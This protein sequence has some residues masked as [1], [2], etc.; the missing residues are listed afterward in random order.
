LLIR[1]MFLS[2]GA[3]MAALAAHSAP[4]LEGPPARPLTDPRSIESPANSDASPAS[5]ADLYFARGLTDAA[6]SPDGQWIVISTNLTGRYNLWRLPAAGGFPEQLTVSDDRNGDIA[7]TRGGQVLF[8][9][10][11]AGKEIYDLWAVP[12]SGG[13]SVNLTATPEVSE[14]GAIAAPD[15]R[16]IVFNRRPKSS[17]STDVAIIDLP[18]RQVRALTHEAAPDHTWN[19]VGFA[20]GG[21]TIIADRGDF[22]DVEQSVWRIDAGSGAAVAVSPQAGA[23]VRGE[24]VSPDGRWVAVTFETKAGVRQ[25][26]LISVAGGQVTPL[27]P[28]VW[29]QSAEDFSPDGKVLI[30]AS[31][32]DG[33]RTLYAYDLASRVSKPLP[34]PAGYSALASSSHESFSPDGASLLAVRQSSNASVELWIVDLRTW[35]AAP[36]THLGLASL[37][38]EHLPASQVVHYKSADGTVV[39]AFLWMPFNLRRDGRAPGVVLPHGGPT[40]QTVDTFNRFALALASRGYVAL[41]PNPRGSTGYGRAFEEGNRKDLGGGDLEDE[42]AGA[43]FLAA[44]G[45]VDPARIGITGGSYGG[46]M[47]LM[48]VAKTPNVWAAGVEQYGIIDWVHM[49]ETEAPPLQQYQRGLLGDPVS[50]AAVYRAASPMTFMH[51]TRAPLLV[52]QGDNDI[53]VPRS[54]AEQV[55]ATLKADG[56][57]VEAHFY[58]NEGHGFVKRE[59]QIDALERTI[60]WFDRYLLP[61]AATGR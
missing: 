61:A 14:T 2:L 46:Y 31:N 60:A 24:A 12:L 49:Y 23:Y 18:S 13:P 47:T 42:V 27:R 29:E 5:I 36:I 34:L 10:D 11:L 19:A 1:Q 57:V 22:R 59:N 52:L 25:A 44:T 50:D 16:A 21:R 56:R 54:Q 41:A 58:P 7:I 8:A 26:G 40:G 39:S 48:A 30:F 43:K 37:R 9:A 32:V 28:D 45:Y 6:W 3:T 20:D 33:R 17:P 35:T 53:R 15:G 51:Q 38:P 4:V 55:V